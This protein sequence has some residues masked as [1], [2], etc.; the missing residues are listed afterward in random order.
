MSKRKKKK[1]ELIGTISAL[2]LIKKTRGPEEINFQTGAYNTK[3]DKP[4]DKNWKRWDY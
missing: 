4:R 2:D 1:K 3:K